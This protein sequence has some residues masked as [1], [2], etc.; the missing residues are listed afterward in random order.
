MDFSSLMA[1]KEKIET[2]IIEYAPKLGLAILI[3]ILGWTAIKIAH[4]LTGRYADRVKMDAT[5]KPFILGLLNV[6]LRVTLI[7][8]ILGI[9][10][11]QTSSFIAILGAAGLAIGLALKD[12]LSNFAS[13]IFLLIYKQ[14]QVGNFVSTEGGDGTVESI[15]LFQ[16]ILVTPDQK[17][18]YVPNSKLITGSVTN[19]SQRPTRRNDL[20]FGIGYGD[21]IDQ[22]RE[23]FTKLIKE[24][25]RI[26]SEPKAEVL[27][28]GLLDSSVEITVRYWVKS[29][30]YWPVIFD[31]TEKGKKALDAAGISIPFPQRDLH[32]IEMPKKDA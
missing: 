18:V 26:L 3:F 27:V 19:F 10:G 1:N 30:N 32:I 28:T 25:E 20:K 8:S 5:V 4:N 7:I 2:L 13:G 17:V 9:L 16:T 6:V 21:S 14:A 24:E 31:F 29:D 15:S 11:V 23:V 12:N 22:A